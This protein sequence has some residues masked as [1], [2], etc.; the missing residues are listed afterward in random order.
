VVAIDLTSDG[1][2]LPLSIGVEVGSR[3]ILDA[4]KVGGAAR[5][6]HEPLSRVDILTV[7]LVNQVAL[8]VGVHV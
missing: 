8:S 1:S 5:L 7:E 6:Q 4:L 3:R 2:S